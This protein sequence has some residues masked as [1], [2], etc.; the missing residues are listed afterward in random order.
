MCFVSW[1]S[2]GESE[3]ISQKSH[4]VGLSISV[5]D[6]QTDGRTHKISHT[7]TVAK[8][9]AQIEATSIRTIHLDLPLDT[10]RP[11]DWNVCCLLC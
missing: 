10:P 2:L 3:N 9:S 5:R 6:R 4:T 7:R 11:H 1:C 8:L